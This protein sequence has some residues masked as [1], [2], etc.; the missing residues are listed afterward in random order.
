ML[1]EVCSSIPLSGS[2]YVWAAE[3]GGRRWGRL[4]GFVVAFWATTAWTSFLA[5][6][7][8]GTANY[9]L[10]ELT[11]FQIVFPGGLDSSNV[12]FRAV[13]WAIAQGF[14]WSAVLVNW[15]PPKAFRWVFF[16]SAAIMMADWLLTIIWLPIGVSK[17]YG[18]QS[19]SFFTEYFN[20]TGAPTGWNWLLSFLFTSGVLTGFDASGHVAEETKNASLAAARGIFWSCAISAILGTP[21][22][23]LYL[24]C[25]PDL[26]TLY[27]YEAPQPFV[28]IYEL[29]L[30]RAGQLIMTIVSIFGLWLNTVMVLI[31]ASRLVFAIARDGVLPGSSWIGRVKQ[32]GQPK[33][34]VLFCGIVASTILHT[35]LASPVAFTSLISAGA[36]PT[37]AAYALIPALRLFVTPGE[38]K[39]AKWS[40]GRL[41]T[42]FL[43]ISMFWNLFLMATLISPYY[44]PVTADTFNFA[45]VILGAV[46]IFAFVAYWVIPEEKWLSGKKIQEIRDNE[47]FSKQGREDQK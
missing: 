11:I 27:S 3:C 33:N 17:T 30:G 32:N 45:P 23:F 6:I 8:T 21:I 1:A 25:S 2:I 41:S 40:N 12:K 10:S 46:T 18:F 42:P 24:A 15:I 31:A 19:K 26:D 47:A 44:F 38:L 34:A 16:T 22:I 39:T 13:Q 14:L 43:W 29:A 20:G 4:C 35:V 37:I 36:I 7:N 28:V 9:L 5:G